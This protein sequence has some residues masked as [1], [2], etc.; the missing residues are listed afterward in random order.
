MS[1]NAVKEKLV[2]FK[3]KGIMD[4]QYFP[5]VY[6]LASICL[7][8]EGNVKQ[9]N[10]LARATLKHL[11]S[12]TA[13]ISEDDEKCFIMARVPEETAYSLLV[14]LPAKAIE[15]DLAM[16]GYRVTAYAGYIH[17]LYQRLLQPGGSDDIWDSDVSGLLSQMR[18]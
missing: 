9:L 13:M 15:Y 2:S 4:I 11:P 8:I 1:R 3:N 16:K 10:S 5:T 18:S 17:N 6:G 7:E 12:T 14:N